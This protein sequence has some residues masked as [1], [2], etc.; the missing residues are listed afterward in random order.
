M[1]SENVRRAGWSTGLDTG[2]VSG[3]SASPACRGSTVLDLKP[4]DRVTPVLQQLLGIHVPVAER[5]Q[6][7]LCFLVHKLLLAATC[8]LGSTTCTHAKAY[9]WLTSVAD[10]PAR[11]RSTLCASSSSGDVVVPRTRPRIG[12]TALSVAAPRA[13]NRLPTQLK[14]LRSTD[15]FHRQ[16][17][18]S[19]PVCNSVYGHR[20]QTDGCLVD[21]LSVSQ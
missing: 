10:V 3:T 17:N 8:E 1:R 4:H 20:E 9:L 16:L 2:T 18:I 21:A 19:I 6:Y 5:I 14:L 7:K 12:D 11:A 15:T 13:W